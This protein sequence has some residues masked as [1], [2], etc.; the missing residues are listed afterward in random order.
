MD[1]DFAIMRR[2]F[3]GKKEGL[4]I[5]IKYLEILVSKWTHGLNVNNRPP[6][7]IDTMT[8]NKLNMMDQKVYEIRDIIGLIID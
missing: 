3:E 1:K 8:D 6:D 4:L 7:V 5:W 2:Y